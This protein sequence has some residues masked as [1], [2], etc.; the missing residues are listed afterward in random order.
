MIA[1]DWNK[2]N[3][4]GEENILLGQKQ[5][6]EKRKKETKEGYLVEWTGLH[7]RYTYY[8]AYASAFGVVIFLWSG[9]STIQPGSFF[10]FFFFWRR[11]RRRQSTCDVS[12]PHYFFSL[13]LLR[14]L[15]FIPPPSF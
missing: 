5:E 15:S 12:L 8:Y 11:R 7:P 13:L 2:V 9:F 1:V 10:F 3:A 14:F 6:T 4:K